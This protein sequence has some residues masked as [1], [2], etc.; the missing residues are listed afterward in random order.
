MCGNEG[1]F[2]FSSQRARANTGTR[3]PE[4]PFCPGCY[5]PSSHVGQSMHSYP[6]LLFFAVLQGFSKFP[7]EVPPSWAQNLSTPFILESPR[8]RISFVSFPAYNGSAP[9]GCFSTSFS[10]GAS[11]KRA[12]SSSDSRV[13]HLLL[14]IKSLVAFSSEPT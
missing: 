9:S 14:S 6:C 5:K 8:S 12:I 13:T 1:R 4:F 7:D 11:G 10:V 2:L 3:N